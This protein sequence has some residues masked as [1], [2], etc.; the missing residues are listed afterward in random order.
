MLKRY[1]AIVLGVGG[2]GSAAL[3]HLADRG[4]RTLGIEQFGIAHDRGS[5][6]GE[7]RAIRKAYFEHPDYVPLIERAYKN[8]FDLEEQS[9]ECGSLLVQ[10]GILEVGP[11]DGILIPGLRDACK[12]HGLTLEDVDG[13]E[14]EGRFPG[15]RLPAGNVAVYEPDGGF[16]HVERCIKTYIAQ[17]KSLGAD[18][19][20]DQPV[21]QWKAIGGGIELKTSQATYYADRLVITAGAWASQMLGQC[22]IHFKVLRKHLHWYQVPKD[23]YAISSGSP[24]F[25]YERPEGCY[26]GFP[27]LESDSRYSNSIKIAEHSGGEIILDPNHHDSQRDPAEVNRVE[28]FLS[29]CMPAVTRN[30]LGHATCMYTMSTDEHFIIDQHPEFE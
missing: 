13:Q 14:F 8:W 11:V 26:Y 1:D 23:N 7:T 24:V 29:D 6:H 21:L 25:F 9:G 12:K 27:C 18:L 17:A 15:F 19:V 30:S 10:Q 22:G 16:L 2:V 4:M 3:Y 28:R 20:F 5:S